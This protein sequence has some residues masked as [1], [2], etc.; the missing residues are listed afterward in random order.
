MSLERVCGQEGDGGRRERVGKAAGQE[1]VLRGE[2]KRR[3]RGGGE[4]GH[5]ASPGEEEL[6]M[7]NGVTACVFLRDRKT[8]G[9]K[10]ALSN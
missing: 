4:P 5:R 10:C 9:K 2:R 7:R 6:H 1:E 3:R 8:L